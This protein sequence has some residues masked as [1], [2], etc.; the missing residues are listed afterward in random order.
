[1]LIVANAE[2]AERRADVRIEGGRIAEIGQRLRG[3]LVLDAKGGALIPG[4]HDHHI[5]LLA[6]A[7]SLRS[8]TVSPESVKGMAG[9]KATL[10]AASGHWIRA[11]LYHDSV[12]GP[13]DRDVLDRLEPHRPVRVQYATGSL[14]VLNSAALRQVLPPGELPACVE[15]GEDGTP[16]GRIWR[17]DAW[18][19]GRLP[20]D[21]PDLGE[22]G[23]LL[24]SCGVTGV[25]DTSATTGP[26]EAAIFSDA[27]RSGALPQRLMLMSGGALEGAAEYRGGPVKILLDDHDL[28][29]LD[30]LAAR[31][32]QA[33]RWGR[34]VAVHC[35]T[36]AELAIL[37]AAF[38]MEGARRGDRIE[39]GGIIPA[40]ALPELKRLGLTVVTQPGFIAGRGD[41][42][43]RDVETAELPDL[44]RCASLMRAGIAVAGS[45][46]APYTASD[47]WAAIKAA[48]A[49]RTRL[50]HVIGPDE[51][52]PPHTALDL[53]LGTAERP[54]KPRR[55][56]AGM[57][58]DLCLLRL[59]LREAL[60]APDAG[61]VA[62]T[63]IGGRIA[64]HTELQEFAGALP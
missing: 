7:A 3:G 53:F 6:L 38:H 23:R 47:P 46:D 14:W 19:R 56:T 8:V 55:I 28:P 32:R 57:R 24:A 48:T 43:L 18:L 40:E 36:A 58:A 50:G 39:H 52:V 17:G 31:I 42:Y 41:R 2:I 30:D 11:T 26:G 61:N 13:L 63:L 33:R 10:N 49:R 64:Y 54:A 51:T 21:P 45:T 60:A 34:G 16:T 62:A 29:D 20:S 1:M 59:P 4:L 5:H 44:Y 22:V 9:L 27:V 15:R 37:L 25:T 35:V 12:A